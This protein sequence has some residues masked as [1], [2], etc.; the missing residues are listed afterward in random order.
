MAEKKKRKNGVEIGGHAY[1]RITR[2]TGM[3]QTKSG[4]WVPEYK[5]FYGKTNKEAISKYEQ[6]M[7]VNARNGVLNGNT[8]LGEFISWWEENV[9]L[10][11]STLAEGT[12]TLHINSFHNVF[13]GCRIMGASVSD[14][15]GAD[16]Q[17]VFSS[18]S[19]GATTKR[20]ARSFL[21]R[22][23]IYLEMQHIAMN[24]TAGLVLPK[25]KPRKT[26]QRI[27][28]FSNDDINRFLKNTP[29]D[30]RLR[31]LIVLAI[32]T[33]ARVGELCA[34]TYSD[35]E[36]GKIRINKQLIEVDPLIT[37]RGKI[38]ARAEIAETKTK[39]SVRTLPLEPA[40]FIQKE[41]A[42]HRKW[43]TDEMLR[44]KYRTEYVFTTA[45]GEL[46]FKS[47]LRT[48]FK[49]LCLR[50]DVEPKSIHVFRHTFGTKLAEA[51]VPIQE[52][53]KLM[54]HDSID[55]TAKYYINLNDERKRLA[56]QKMSFG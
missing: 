55:V 17:A 45:R 54:G 2:K 19:I 24:I 53:S 14:I 25:V 3:K 49:R 27:V 41:I 28:T 1:K 38:K 12:K 50:V 39:S 18:S 22:F 52:V 37:E 51:G 35:I 7:S 32:Y 6:Y 13:D 44:N 48:A 11:D 8:C 30:H 15:T 43:H 36:N 46:Y 40:N 56:L 10:K 33:G 4:K 42:N 47:S 9:Y 26:D 34:L 29:T 5:C 23:Y 31:L 21:K 20:H 16:L